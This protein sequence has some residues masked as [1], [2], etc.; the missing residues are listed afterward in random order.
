MPSITMT[1]DQ[2]ELSPHNVRTHRADMLETAAIERSLLASG[3]M[4]PLLVHPWKGR[5][6]RWG[7]FAGGRRWRSFK[8]LVERGD[9]PADHPID[10]V[11][12]DLSDAELTELSLAENLVRRDLRPYE[13]YAAVLK[14]Q[15][16]GAGPEEIAR[17]TGQELVWVR[18]ALRLA[19][20]APVLL[21]ALETDRL[22]VDQAQAFGATDDQALQARVW[23]ELCGTGDM[24]GG[25]TTPAIIRARLKVGDPELQKLLRFVGDEAYRAAGGRFEL[26]LFAGQAEQRG[27]VADESVLRDLVDVKLGEI[28]GEWRKSLGREV[29][30]QAKPPQTTWGS[31][32][33][34]LEIQPT[35]NA[36]EGAGI[37][38]PAGD[39]VGTI[40]IGPD[41]TEN[42]R[43]W[44]ASHAAKRGKKPAANGIATPTAPSR[45]ANRAKVGTGAAILQGEGY[46]ARQAADAQLKEQEGLTA[47]GVTILRS[48]RRA[49]LRAG[50]VQAAHEGST[51]GRDYLVWAQLR[52]RLAITGRYGEAD[53]SEKI[54]M[55]PLAASD[56]D[57]EPAHAFLA[58]SE[59]GRAW[60]AAIAEIKGQLFLTEPDPP[61]AFA[62]YRHAVQPVKLLAEAVVAGLALER[63]LDADGYRIAVHDEL[64]AHAGVASEQ[65]VRHWWQPTAAFLELLPTAERRAIAQPFLEP[66]AFAGWTKLKSAELTPLVL[67]VVQG[68]AP[69]TKKTMQI[70][71]AQWVHPLL[72]F[73]R[74]NRTRDAF[75]DQ[76]EPDPH[77]P[78]AHYFVELA[79]AAE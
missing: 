7:V 75:V 47:D 60:Q 49:I 27:R 78:A 15:K 79:E 34:A 25:S 5:K 20:L 55:R 64:A 58:E 53:G 43:F 41:G 36:T 70:A 22:S 77:A 39:V 45:A 69:S 12:R 72:T 44:W 8:N 33:H 62:L 35:V 67:R 18:R 21:A 29:R 63:S 38:L 24:L 6:D 30:F 48:L 32:D 61:T 50:L 23:T 73:A 76:P 37:E 26:D 14:A 2:L 42:V 40:D 56:P 51:L 17:E 10:V 57:G 54:G 74:P 68:T 1:I 4:F 16:R 59:A 31:T 71:A 11:V 66:A 9:L 19:T 13:I 3:Q 28:R 52:M 65:A 46:G